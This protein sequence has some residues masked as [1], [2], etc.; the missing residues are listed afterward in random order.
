MTVDIRDVEHLQSVINRI[1][2]VE[3]VLTVHRAGS[4]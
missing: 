2:Q 3:G 4:S 1:T